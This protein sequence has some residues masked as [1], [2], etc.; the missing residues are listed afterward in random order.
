MLGHKVNGVKKH[1]SGLTLSAE[2]NK[3][4]ESIEIKGDK[5]LV[6]VGRAAFTN[7]LNLDS[8][9]LKLNKQN[10]KLG[11]NSMDYDIIWN[12]TLYK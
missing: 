10:K 12:F 4:K 3:S 1:K 7:G 8:I 2:N 9:G 5:C 6:S 11:N